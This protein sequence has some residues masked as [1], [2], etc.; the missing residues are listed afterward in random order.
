MKEPSATPPT[1]TDILDALERASAAAFALARALLVSAE[2]ARTHDDEWTRLP[3]PTARCP[4]SKWSRSTILRYIAAGTIRTKRTRGGRFY[5]LADV[6]ALL[7][8]SPD[9]SK[10]ERHARGD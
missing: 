6:R 1:A 10:P 7:A 3:A 4:V 2:A 8:G 5:P 9:E